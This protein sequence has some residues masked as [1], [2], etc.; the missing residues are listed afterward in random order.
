[1]SS[2]CA[3]EPKPVERVECEGCAPLTVVP[4]RKEKLAIDLSQ[5]PSSMELR[6]ASWKGKP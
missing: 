1:M 5:V 2:R 6:A 3:A 4:V